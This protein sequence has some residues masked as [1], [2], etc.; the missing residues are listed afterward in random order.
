MAREM[1]IFP[2]I[3]SAI[4]IVQ[5]GATIYVINRNNQIYNEDVIINKSI[6]L[7]TKDNATIKPSKIGIHVE[8]DDVVVNGFTIEGGE[9]YGVQLDNSRCNISEN[10]IQHSG[11]CIF[12][13]RA[14]DSQISKNRLVHVSWDSL[15]LKFSINITVNNNYINNANEYG[16]YLDRADKNK[17]TDN[18]IEDVYEN[19]IFLDTSDD[20]TIS[21]NKFK[22]IS[23]CKILAYHSENNNI[24][25][26][27]TNISCLDTTERC[28]CYGL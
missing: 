13:N 7:I 27:G 12:I 5:S 9:Y 22:G 20:N 6:K 17:I 24:D 2:T 1:D 25:L 11:V 4:N 26:D 23:K 18:T 19:G 28:R 16:V 8:A 10:I 21:N 15:W 3:Q 14:K